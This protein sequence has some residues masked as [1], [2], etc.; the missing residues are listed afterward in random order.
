MNVPFENPALNNLIN[1]VIP[2]SCVNSDLTTPIVHIKKQ[3][4]TFLLNIQS[5]GD[6]QQWLSDGS[7]FKTTK[8]HLLQNK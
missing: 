8:S 5:I 4:K 7:N 2:G 6:R 3:T 1:L